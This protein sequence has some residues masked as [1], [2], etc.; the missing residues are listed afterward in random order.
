ME[1]GDF[2]C[3]WSMTIELTVIFGAGGWY[4]RGI[5]CCPALPCHPSSPPPCL[6][7]V[8][9]GETPDDEYIRKAVG[10]ACVFSGRAQTTPLSEQHWA[11]FPSHLGILVLLSQGDGRGGGGSTSTHAPVPY[12][13][14]SPIPHSLSIALCP[15]TALPHCH[16]RCLTHAPAR[17]PGGGAGGQSPVLRP[18]CRTPPPPARRPPALSWGLGPAPV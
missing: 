12:T 13:R 15:R 1:S 18:P 9:I 11:F 5:G 6:L 8:E 3:W 2:F 4:F 7:E 14:P 17:S 10:N 16:C